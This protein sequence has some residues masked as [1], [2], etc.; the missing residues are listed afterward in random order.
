MDNFTLSQILMRMARQD[1]FDGV[2]RLLVTDVQKGVADK[3]LTAEKILQVWEEAYPTYDT[4][5]RSDNVI[6]IFW[7]GRNAT[8][9]VRGVREVV[10]P[11]HI[12]DPLKEEDEAEVKEDE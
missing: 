12:I 6:L 8:R 4:D 2:G 3:T 5:Q 10:A 11:G 9:N 7:D 1:T